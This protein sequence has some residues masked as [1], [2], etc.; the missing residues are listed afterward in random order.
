MTESRLMV[1]RSWGI[2]YVCGGGGILAAKEQG[3]LFGWSECSVSFGGGYMTVF[4]CQN[5]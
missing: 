4:V 1:A 5:S 3:E 2:V